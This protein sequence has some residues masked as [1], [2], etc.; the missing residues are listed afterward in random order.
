MSGA[1]SGALRARR[2]SGGKSL[3]AYLT[4]GF[5]GWQEMVH[6]AAAAGAVPIEVGIPFSDPVMDGPIIQEASGA[7]RWPQGPL[8]RRSST[9]CP[10]WTPG[11][12]WPS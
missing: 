7:G 8:R 9:S 2:D 3:V 6:A 1:L 11:C 10:A 5:P 12:R 4:G